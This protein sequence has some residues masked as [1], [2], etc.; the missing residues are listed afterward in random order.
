MNI[1]PLYELIFWIILIAACAALAFGQT[2]KYGDYSE[3]TARSL[4]LRDI[5]AELK[6]RE[7]QLEYQRR[8]AIRSMDEQQLLQL[9][10]MIML[11]QFPQSA[12]QE[13]SVYEDRMPNAA[14]R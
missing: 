12:P 8:Q 1:K 5:N 3:H 2:A 7:M 4:L 6:S 10:E 14:R 9:K 13:E 11:Q